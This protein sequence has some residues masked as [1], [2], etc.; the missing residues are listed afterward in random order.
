MTAKIPYGWADREPWLELDFP[1]AEFESRVA[2]LQTAM[3]AADIDALLVWDDADRGGNIR[4]LSGFNMVWGTSVVLIHRQ[5]APVLV[6]NA[7]AH[8]EPMHSNIQT[9]WLRDVRVSFA[10]SADDLFEKSAAVLAEWGVPDDRVVVAGHARIPYGTARR[11]AN[12]YGERALHAGDSLLARQRAIKSPAEIAVIRRAAD[13]TSRAMDAAMRAAVPGASESEVAAAAN[14]ACIAAGAERMSFGCFPATGRRGSLKNVFAR[15][16]G[17]IAPT[18]LVV[19]DLGCKL[20][21]YQSDMSRNVVAHPSKQIIALLDAVT[22]AND[23]AFR[24][25]RPGVTTMSVVEV[26]NEAIAERGFSAWDFSLCHGFGLDL[27]E[28]PLFRDHPPMKLEAGMCF[29]VE[30]IIADHSFGC[31]CIEDMLLVTDDGCEKLSHTLV[32][33]TGT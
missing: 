16:G 1:V 17:I 5:R 29:Y 7:V 3:T 31:A 33:A 9:S 15:P 4:Y 13:L 30:P 28:T 19:I 12:A 20:L 6:T 8:G 18:D 24:H 23:A 21:G 14:Y 10:R 25:T 26:M 11:L 27:T 22:A 2:S 32:P